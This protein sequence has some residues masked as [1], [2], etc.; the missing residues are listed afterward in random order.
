MTTALLRVVEAH[1]KT[2][3]DSTSYLCLCLLVE[4]LGGGLVL[5]MVNVDL[6]YSLRNV[7]RNLESEICFY[8]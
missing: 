4:S 1:P 2:S 8:F 6:K 3:C 7:K 5:F